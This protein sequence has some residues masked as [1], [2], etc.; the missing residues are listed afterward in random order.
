MERLLTEY[1]FDTL[2]EF[3]SILFHNPVRG[4]PDPRGKKHSRVVARFLRGRT[5]I[6]M[7]DILPLIYKHKASFPSSKSLDVHEQRKMFDTAGLADKINHAR[8]FLSTWATRLVASEGRKQ[9][10]RCTQ[11]DPDG[12][13]HGV[14]L[15]DRRAGAQVVSMKQLLP[16]FN[17]KFLGTRYSIR[18][19]LVWF[20]TE[21]WAAPM[22]KGALF[23][24][25]RR[26]HPIIQVG[27]IASFI[28][29]RDRYAN[30]DLATTL[31]IWNFA[32]KAHVDVKRVL[33]GL[34]C[35]ISDTAARDALNTITESSR[36]EL[37]QKVKDAAERGETKLCTVLGNVQVRC[38]VDE[39][40]IG[41]KRGL[42]VGTAGTGVELDDCA[43]AAFQAEPYHAKAALHKRK[44]LTTDDLFDDI[45]WPH[46]RVAIPCQW[47][48]TLVDFASDL[49]PLSTEIDAIFRGAL[50]LHRMREGRKSICHPLATNGEC[51]PSLQ[52]F[53]R[54]VN[55]FDHQMGIK[56]QEPGNLLSWIRGDGALY[57]NALRLSSLCAPQGTFK[58]KIATPEIWHAGATDLNSTAANHYGPA[59]SSD[60]S[61]LSRASDVAGLKR[62]SEVKSCDYYP[63]VRNLTLIWK[64]HV[65]DCWRIYLETDD[66]QLYFRDLAAK[67]ELPDLSV[68]LGYAMILVDR[69]ATQSAIQT[70]L[71]ES[72]STDPARDNKVP[73][74]SR[75]TG[76]SSAPDSSTAQDED[77]D[78][79]GLADI[80]DLLPCAASKVPDDSPKS[81]QEKDDFTGDRVLRNS[82]IF[83]QDFGWWI[84]FSKA[85]PEGDIGRVWE[86]MKI[87]IFKFAGSSQQNYVNY[88]LEVY[89]MLR[90]EA[91]EDLRDGILNNWLLNIK[92]ELGE[93]IPA[94]LH[95]ER[96]SKWLEDMMQKHG[97]EFDNK[98]Y[99][100]TISPNVHHFLQIKEEIRTAFAFEP[101][102]E[103]HTSPDVDGE[104]HL[105]LSVF[106]EE[107]V[108]F[109]RSGRSMGH[110]A[111]NQFARGSRRLEE[112]K[113]EDF[114]TGSTVLG[115]FLAEMRK[116]SSADGARI[117]SDSQRDQ[118]ICIS[119]PQSSAEER[120]EMRSD[121]PALNLPESNSSHNTNETRT[122][123]RS[124]IAPVDANEPE[125]DG[126]DRSDAKLTSFPTPTV[127]H[128]S[129]LESQEDSVDSSDDGEEPWDEEE[130]QEDDLDVYEDEEDGEDAPDSDEESESESQRATTRTTRC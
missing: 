50:A 62:P 17:L 12:P 63:T 52:G 10:G 88:L 22:S 39:Q 8:P 129:K 92:G 76:L 20:M 65:L 43:P 33:C 79:P 19:P 1:S 118:N 82:Q 48:S 99:R 112:G 104:L 96:Y 16:H 4:E 122:S 26:P 115:D 85:V 114:L 86:I 54:A 47:A 32:C 116:P 123:Y 69:Y 42:K 66:L 70:S 53:E 34:G 94:D 59:T 117:G 100:Q 107:E 102:G 36:G 21:V 6:K 11:D 49:H 90:Y 95:Q 130:S 68:L 81:H 125:D 23:V 60:P 80:E 83:L 9:V 55:D 105:L 40:G 7:S 121:S 87:W 109:F 31:G 98:F 124:S 28:L 89:C 24:R 127:D 51:S 57:A 73:K 74:G 110:V 113:L 18:L 106:K 5:A 84:E 101:R 61:S 64:A 93:W 75:W 97:G 30:G 103:T 126:D 119:R 120:E 72:D 41:R 111:V 108:H 35:A 44:T 78:M 25:K 29:S 58:N 128:E 14:Q 71:S 13:E 37:Q 27:A 46:M 45:N 67:E 15:K 38:D 91:S 77:A 56:S 2:G 3:L